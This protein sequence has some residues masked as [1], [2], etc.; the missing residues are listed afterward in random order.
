MTCNAHGCIG[1]MT[2][3]FLKT[4]PHLQNPIEILRIFQILAPPG[5][6]GGTYVL[7]ASTHVSRF[8]RRPLIHKSQAWATIF[9]TEDDRRSS[10]DMC[11]GRSYHVSSDLTADAC[12]YGPVHRLSCNCEKGWRSRPVSNEVK[13]RELDSVLEALAETRHWKRIYPLTTTSFPLSRRA[14]ATLTGEL[15]VLQ[16][17]LV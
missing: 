3:T 17:A 10:V 12:D 15:S 5:T 6:R 11:L 8:W 16:N 7:F 1:S 14:E 2:P 4:R 9:T 13:P